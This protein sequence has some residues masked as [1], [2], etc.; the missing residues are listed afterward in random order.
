M[1]KSMLVSLVFMATVAYGVIARYETV[2]GGSPNQTYAQLSYDG[3]SVNYT[4]SWLM[5][6]D[7]L[8]GANHYS[9]GITKFD[10]PD[11]ILPG[12][13]INSARIEGYFHVNSGGLGHVYM[14]IKTYTFDNDVFPITWADSPETAS[15]Y[16]VAVLDFN[17]DEGNYW[18]DIT[19]DIAAK[20]AA[21]YDF[22]SYSWWNTEP[23]GVP[24]ENGAEV[25][26]TIN[27]IGFC[28]SDLG[29]AI[30]HPALVIDYTV[31]D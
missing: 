21:G 18:F 11:G 7:H 27:M 16:D 28:G 23:N 5:I 1:K 13:T 29:P 22:A 17:G 25:P 9:D 15:M 24:R 10:I 6:G 2:G 8:H 19:A 12:A 4:G 3:F 20:V 30:D 31:P 26:P 14:G